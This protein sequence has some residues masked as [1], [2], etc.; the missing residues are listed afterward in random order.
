MIPNH[1]KLK[2]DVFYVDC[3]LLQDIQEQSFE[4]GIDAPYLVDV[5]EE[6]VEI[7]SQVIDQGIRSSDT[8][9]KVKIRQLY[10]N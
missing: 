10:Q 5:D 7:V 3:F 2:N 6:K 9:I 8:G 1:T 4:F